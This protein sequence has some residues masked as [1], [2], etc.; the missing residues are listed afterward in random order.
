MDENNRSNTEQI[1]Q[2]HG[3]YFKK[4]F[5]MVK[6][7]EER[8]LSVYQGK[9]I[10]GYTLQTADKS[11]E[12]ACPKFYE[13]A[14]ETLRKSGNSIKMEN[15]DFLKQIPEQWQLFYLGVLPIYLHCGWV[16]RD[17]ALVSQFN[18]LVNYLYW[19]R[20]AKEVTRT[21][22]RESTNQYYKDYFDI[23][24]KYFGSTHP[25][26]LARAETLIVCVYEVY[27]KFQT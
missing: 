9:A 6:E 16:F 4:L 7:E 12:S 26:I 24:K 27:Q 11:L 21:K 13:K 18:F 2:K 15:K 17:Q 25:S 10:S 5:E 14:E 19:P 8:A 1:K 20:K 3:T 22:L 23:R